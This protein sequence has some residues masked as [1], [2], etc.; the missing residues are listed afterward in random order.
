MQREV[1]NLKVENQNLKRLLLC[2]GTGGYGDRPVKD[3]LRSS[4]SFRE[5]GS[6]SIRPPDFRWSLADSSSSLCDLLATNLSQKYSL[7]DLNSSGQCRC[8]Q[9]QLRN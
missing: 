2:Q 3:G 1:N 6:S 5:R 7:T 4:M 9:C 8:S